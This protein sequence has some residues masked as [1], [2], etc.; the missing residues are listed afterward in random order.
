[1][2]SYN[3]YVL[4]TF[5][6][7]WKNVKKIITVWIVCYHRYL[8][9]W[10]GSPM[11]NNVLL[12]PCI[13]MYHAVCCFIFT[14]FPVNPRLCAAI[15]NLRSN[16]GGKSNVNCVITLRSQLSIQYRCKVILDY[17]YSLINYWRFTVMC[18]NV[19]FVVIIVKR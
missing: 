8:V 1:M 3:C 6:P 18:P 7:S 14:F 9:V 5:I 10:K 15:P 19:V 13:L 16:K 12:Y 17:S 4:C 11:H 2:S